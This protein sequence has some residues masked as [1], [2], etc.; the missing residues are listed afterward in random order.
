M[1]HILQKILAALAR[2]AV[3]KYKPF[4]VGI[5]GSVGKTSTREAVAAVLG[6]KYRVRSPEKN[7]NNEIG[8]PL[9]ILGMRH[10]GSNIAAWAAAFLGAAW[11]IARRA[12]YPE[13]VI[14]EYGV[15][16]PGDMEYLLSIAQPDIAVVTA[17]GDVPVHVEFFES[18]E[19]LIAE[20]AKLVRALP[21]AGCAVVNHD[22]YAV[23]AMADGAPRRITY[24]FERDANVRV[25]DGPR[26]AVHRDADGRDIPAGI[27]FK[28]E[29]GGSAVPI[30]LHGAFG[31]GA[32]YAAAAAAAV[33]RARGMNLA[34]IAEA[35]EKF[36]TPPGRLRLLKGVKH[37]WIVD[38]TYNAA[39]ESMRNA[40]EV[41]RDL[42]A[43]RRIAVLGDMRELGRFSIEAHRAIGDAASRVADALYAV[44]P[45]AKFIA[46]EARESGL[47]APDR[48]LDPK[49]IFTFDDAEAAGRALDPI[50]GDGDII[51]AKGSRAVHLER[52]VKEIMAEPSRAAELLVGD[53][54]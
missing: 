23:L 9:T 41:L 5:T 49:N 21:A 16:R 52:A 50:I 35:L 33:G 46:E 37:S 53:G 2:A 8:L 18:P 44:G 4:V 48:A 11:S 12:P 25:A 29:E 45:H 14:L 13:I 40:L 19:A 26:L 6:A 43:K 15:D 20:K 31:S 30:R 22:D 24:G 38:D 34:E 36:K 1:K 32:A 47:D 10:C 17:I 28:L 7:Y 51:L 39:P 3:R 27:T 42:P 54:E